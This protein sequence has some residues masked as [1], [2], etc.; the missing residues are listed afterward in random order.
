MRIKELYIPDH[1]GFVDFKISFSQDSTITTIIGQNGVGKS[2]LIEII[3]TIFSC[4]ELGDA[5]LFSYS[6]TYEC[7]NH[8]IVIRYDHSKTL[9]QSIVYVDNK[10]RSFSF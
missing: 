4:I 7:R 8:E 9:G 2:N 10:K 3:V 6:L 1:K 5:C